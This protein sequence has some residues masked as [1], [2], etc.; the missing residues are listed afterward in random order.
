MINAHSL[1]SGPCPLAGQYGEHA[2][3]LG[4]LLRMQRVARVASGSTVGKS[5]AAMVVAAPVI[6]G[7]PRA[8][9]RPA[10]PCLT[11]NEETKPLISQLEIFFVSNLDNDDTKIR[12]AADVFDQC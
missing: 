1:P 11:R 10:L 4:V 8:V 9:R 12:R 2:T 3:R 7:K 6:V 5:G